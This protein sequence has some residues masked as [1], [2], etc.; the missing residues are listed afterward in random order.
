MESTG[1]IPSFGPE[2]NEASWQQYIA[3]VPSCAS[4][5]GTNNTFACL[6]A[7][8]TADLEQA[9]ITTRINFANTSFGPVID[10]PGGI[11]PARPSQIKPQG[12]LP[13]LF[14]SNLDEGA[15]FTPQTIDSATEIEDFLTALVSPPIVS[16]ETLAVTIARVLE[17]YPDV[18]ALGSPFGTG[19]ATFGLNSAYKRQAAICEYMSPPC[20]SSFDSMTLRAAGDLIFHSSRRNLSQQISSQGIPVFAY[21]FTDHDAVAFAE[22]AAAEAAPGSL[23][24]AYRC[25]PLF[26]SCMAPH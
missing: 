8:S 6:R 17:L 1:L 14:G 23:G 4:F 19:N 13:T 12:S 11:V 9:I 10:G 5:V 3:A 18:P 25:R 24:G 21:L 7:A 2:R 20:C 22:F 26:T 16:P 15:L